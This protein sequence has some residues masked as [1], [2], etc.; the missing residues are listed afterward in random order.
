M[1][2]LLILALN[3][4]IVQDIQEVEMLVFQEQAD[5]EK[6]APIMKLAP[7]KDDLGLLPEPIVILH[8]LSSSE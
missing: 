2:M 6:S 1:Y 8:A 5:E 7:A 4:F 3:V